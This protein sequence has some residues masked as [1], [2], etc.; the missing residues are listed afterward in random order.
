VSA[1]AKPADLRSRN[2]ERNRAEVAAIALDLF[3][4][5][6]FAEVSVDDIA[7]AAGISR[8]TFFRYFDSK[9]GA[10]LPFEAER[11]DLLRD[12]LASRSPGESLLATVRRATV[13]MVSDYSEPERHLALRR[14]RIV[15]EHPAVHA[16]SLEVLSQWE[17]AV[18][19]VI[20]ADLGEDAATSLTA[21]VTAS[22]AVGAVRAATEVWLRAGGTD[23]PAVLVA[24]A[25]EIL[26]AGLTFA[27]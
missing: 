5:R 7:A 23:D 27:E 10:V 19:E 18:A 22:A 11:L 8:R 25:F 13:T 16:R 21:R 14:L 24:E 9:E 4:A 1:T 2:L 15:N 20:A 17:T 3:D 6:G 12:A 26:R